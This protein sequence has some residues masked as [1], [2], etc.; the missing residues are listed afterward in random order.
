MKHPDDALYKTPP[1][2]LAD[3]S[4]CQEKTL[5]GILMVLQKC[6]SKPK[7]K[8]FEDSILLQRPAAKVKRVSP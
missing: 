6:S 8:G 4:N 3:E 7:P 5:S 1:L 2:P